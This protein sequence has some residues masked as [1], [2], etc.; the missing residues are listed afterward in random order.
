VQR[1]TKWGAVVLA[2]LVGGNLILW[3]FEVGLRD[4]PRLEL[5]W[6]LGF[7]LAALIALWLAFRWTVP[8]QSFRRSCALA[9]GVSAF[10][11]IA[12]LAMSLAPGGPLEALVI[13][14]FAGPMFLGWS[15]PMAVANALL[16]HWAAKP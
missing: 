2:N 9:A 13:A 11:V 4:Q 10:V 5:E 7:S 3:G 12:G 16:F 6:V 14:G 8:G 1:R 15:L